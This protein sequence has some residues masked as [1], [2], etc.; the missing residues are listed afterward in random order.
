MLK[1]PPLF[2]RSQMTRL[3]AV[4][5]EATLSLFLP[6]HVSEMTVVS[7]RVTLAFQSPVSCQS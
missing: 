5:V 1:L 2:T 3:T 4:A 6:I 7:V